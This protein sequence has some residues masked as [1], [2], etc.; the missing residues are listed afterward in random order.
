MDK[1]EIYKNKAMRLEKALRQIIDTRH[2]SYDG[3]LSIANYALEEEVRIEEAQANTA[4]GGI[5]AGVGVRRLRTSRPNPLMP[6][7][8]PLGANM[9]IV[10]LSQLLEVANRIISESRQL[11]DLSER[12]IL[13]LQTGFQKLL[14]GL[15]PR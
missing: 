6:T 4:C 9:V 1:L 14:R 3:M 11:G 13:V 7:V 2:R 5:G 15:T 12:D 10:K 8:N